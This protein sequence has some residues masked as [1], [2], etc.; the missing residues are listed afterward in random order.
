[1]IPSPWTRVHIYRGIILK[2]SSLALTGHKSRVP[3]HMI[4]IYFLGCWFLLDGY[5]SV[6]TFKVCIPAS[7]SLGR[8]GYHLKIYQVGKYLDELR[9]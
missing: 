2:R 5:E 9:S 8:F 4:K 7:T 6:A 3:S 1:L